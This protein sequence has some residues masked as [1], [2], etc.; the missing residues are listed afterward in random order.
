M[1]K[2]V[3]KL[4]DTGKPGRFIP[5]TLTLAITSG[6]RANLANE[7]REPGYPTIMCGQI[8]HPPYM[9]ARQEMSS[10]PVWLINVSEG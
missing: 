7:P 3:L 1:N 2:V 8:A 4:D 5:G 10:S 9:R 6:N